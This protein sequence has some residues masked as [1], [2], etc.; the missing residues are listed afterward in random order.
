MA[1]PL[2]FLMD[3]RSWPA[4]ILAGF[5]WGLLVHGALLWWLCPVSPVGFCLFVMALAMQGLFFGVLSPR[6]VRSGVIALF[7]IPAA[8]VFSEYARNMMLGGFTWGLGMSQSM[9]PEMIQSARFGGVYAVGWLMMFFS[10]ACYRRIRDRGVGVL[11]DPVFFGIL[12][13]PVLVWLAGAVAMGAG[14][15]QDGR[16]VRIGLIQPDISHTGKDDPAQFNEN[17]TAHLRLSQRAVVEAGTAGL[18]LVIW[19]ET[20][21]PDDVLRD[22]FWKANMESAARRLGGWVIFGSALLTQDGHDLNALLFLDPSGRWK[23][24]YLKRHLVP[25]SEFLPA[26]PVSRWLVHA[27]GINSHRFIAGRRRG[28]VRLGNLNVNVGVAICSEEAYPAL[29]RDLA[30]QDAGVLI[31]ALND[32][33]F[34]HAEALSQHAGLAVFR[35]V[36]TGRPLVRAANTGWSV[37]I[38]PNGRIIR[39]L[40]RQSPGWLVAEAYP[41]RGQ[42][43]YTRFGDLFAW[44]CVGFV[45]IVLMRLCPLLLFPLLLMLLLPS[46]AQ[47][48]AAVQRRVQQQKQMQAQAAAQYQQQMMQQQQAQMMAQQQQAQQ[49]AAYQQAMAQRQAQQAAAQQAAAE[50]AA[51]KQAMEQALA[52]KQAQEQQAVQVVSAVQQQQAQQAARYQQA[53]MTNN[54]AAM[55]AYKQQQ[56][57]KAYQE[58]QAQAKLNGDI[59]QYAEYAAKRNAMMQ[60]Q[61]A[62]V[63][64]QATEQQL[65]AHAAVQNA[66]VMK[67]RAE[68]NAAYQQDVRRRLGQSAAQEVLAARTAQGDVP[69]PATA[70]AAAAAA[71]AETT[72]GMQELWSALDKSARPWAQIIDREIKLLTVS[73]FID[74]FRKN[75]IVIAH[76]PGEYVGKIDALTTNNPDM[77]KSP[78]GNLLSYAAIVDY[79]FDN[80][81]NKDELA[82]QILGDANFWANKRRIQGK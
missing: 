28:L 12:L 11:R 22:P 19:P 53:V 14:Q 62:Q 52:Q 38:D 35:A 56:E 26:D 20:A 57:V 40:P 82:R 30:A 65:L 16:P 24:I 78:F 50:Y 76:S 48:A 25:W 23:D 81:H 29:Y 77:L 61:A 69:D 39:S 15:H 68:L 33:W 37:L 4:R 46:D 44:L 5:S 2:L 66:T 54:V 34:S 75:G 10:V 31:S 41:V 6:S 45:I 43:W 60:A 32:G 70:S 17:I 72:I 7:Y 51:Q 21:F 67:Q 80:G 55:V 1:I 18:D 73:E 64:Q 49:V 47:A 36:E 13:I 9:A 59:K 79:D 3:G 58:A 74:R 8:W 27:S 63:A 42:T 71:V